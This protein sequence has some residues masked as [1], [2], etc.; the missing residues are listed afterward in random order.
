ML[1]KIPGIQNSNSSPAA[2]YKDNI[3]TIS[4]TL[5]STHRLSFAYYHIYINMDA[6]HTQLAQIRTRLE[7]IPALQKLEVSIY[8]P[9]QSLSPGS[10][11]AAPERVLIFPNSHLFYRFTY[12]ILFVQ[13]NKKQ[14]NKQAYQKNMSS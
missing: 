10:F 3:H 2:G 11:S 14:R 8:L 7:D 12:I 1:A 4:R 9:C 13:H 6:I 5:C